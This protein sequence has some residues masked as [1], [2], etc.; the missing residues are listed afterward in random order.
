MAWSGPT[1]F[2]LTCIVVAIVALGT[3]AGVMGPV[4]AVGGQATP[5]DSSTTASAPEAVGASAAQDTLASSDFDGR[6]DFLEIQSTG[7]GEY[8]YQFR[9]DGYV[10]K[11]RVNQR[12]K[13]EGNDDLRRNADG[14]VTVTGLTG[15]EQSDAYTFV[16]DIVSFRTVR[17]ESGADLFINGLEVSRTD[18][19]D[20]HF[21]E[22][23]SRDEDEDLTY[24]FRVRGTVERWRT[25]DDIEADDRDRIT[26]RSDGT[27]VV[28]GVTGD[29]AGDAFRI[30]G[31]ILA[32]RK[33]GGDSKYLLR[34]DGLEVD[35]VTLK[36]GVSGGG[37]DDNGDDNGDDG[38]VRRIDE[39]TR[40]DRAGRYVLTR[41]LRNVREDTCLEVRTGGVT[42]DGNGHRIDGV[43]DAGTVGIAVTTRGDTAVRDVTIT[44]IGVSDWGTG[45]RAAGSGRA[46]MTGLVVRDVT[47]AS[48]V[49]MGIHLSDTASSRITDATVRQNGLTGVLF[50]ESGSGNG[51]A[52]STID[53]NDGYGVVI[54]DG[55][56]RMAI[57]ENRITGNRLG[58]I[59]TSND[60]RETEIVDN[61][62][63]D[64]RGNGLRLTDSSEITVSENTIRSNDGSGISISDV[65]GDSTVERNT[66]TENTRYGIVLR[67]TFRTTLERNTVRRNGDSGIALVS[68]QNNRL[69]RNVV[70]ENGAGQQIFI[71]AGS[72]DNVLRDN[73]LSCS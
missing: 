22:V 72:T 17:S 39:C 59:R 54:F 14:T 16:G 36:P 61:L 7:D 20:A 44:D 48:N 38:E 6:I 53:R 65:S 37:D 57:S 63:A 67:Y 64:N 66:V 41:D 49:G 25:A 42:L 43:D 4:P 11:A 62:V 27:T 68:S 52:D 21:L 3:P 23:V 70:C 32:F 8:V 9:V 30:R 13:S 56:T 12:V 10:Q 60:D 69:L 40:I 19:V 55:A 24:E 46:R 45:I 15:N 47:S 51:L 29:E 2:G 26:R 50:E 58:G 1:G 35:P 34:I 18:L 28:R 73:R 31:T 33:T 5:G 71:D